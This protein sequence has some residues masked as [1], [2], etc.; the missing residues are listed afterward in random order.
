MGVVYGK[1]INDMYR[2]WRT[3]NE[4]NFR[5]Y[6]TWANMLCRCYSEKYQEKH[7]TYKGCTVC[8]KW[9]LLSNF[10]EDYRLIDGYD[11]NKFFK[12]ELCLDKD[13]KS[14]GKN[15]E[16]SLINCMWVSKTENTIQ[17]NKTMDYSFIQER[18]CGNITRNK[19]KISSSLLVIT[20]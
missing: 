7:P 15:K 18:T 9:L 20:F 13:I 12:G 3:E 19:N 6:H 4:K 10:I 5:I 14:N 16:Y 2:S 11:E 8:K 1:G 17:S